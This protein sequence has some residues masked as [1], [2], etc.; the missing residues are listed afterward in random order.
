MTKPPSPRHAHQTSRERLREV[1][2]T[3]P[4]STRELSQLS[5]LSED[6]VVTH[7]AHLRKSLKTKGNALEITPS[8]CLDCDF[9]FQKRD[10]LTRPG[11]CPVCRSTHLAAPRFSLRKP[12][13]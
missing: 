8:H 1:L 10:R 6:E 9:V 5:H 12:A 11:K 7:L 2:S 3:A 4:L 13:T